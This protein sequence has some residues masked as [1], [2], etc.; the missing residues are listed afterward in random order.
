RETGDPVIMRKQLTHLTAVISQRLTVQ[1]VPSRGEPAG[2]AGEVNIAKMEDMSEVAHVDTCVRGFTL[3]EPDELA[4]AH[5]VLNEV[6]AMAYSVQ[7]SVEIITRV[8]EEKWN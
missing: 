6:R 3:G 5:Q 2:M 7:E 4:V 8:V 1:I